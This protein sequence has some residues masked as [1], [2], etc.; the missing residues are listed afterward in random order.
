MAAR[1]GDRLVMQPYDLFSDSRGVD[2]VLWGG[3][4]SLTYSLSKRH[5]LGFNLVYNQNGESET[6]LIEGYALERGDCSRVFRSRVLGYTERNLSSEQVRGTHQPLANYPMRIEWQL[7]FSHVKQEQPDV[8]QIADEYMFWYDDDGHIYDTVYSFGSSFTPPARYWRNINE[9]NR[10]FNLNVMLPVSDNLKAKIGGNYAKKVRDQRQWQFYLQ[11]GGS[12]EYNGN[13]DDYL[14]QTGIKDS[15]L[16][17]PA[18]STYRYNMYSYWSNATYARDQYDAH[19]IVSAGFGQL[20]ARVFG[21]L[22]AVLGLRYEKTDMESRN[23]DT[24]K[25]ANIQSGDWLPAVSLVYHAGKDMNLRFAYGRTLARP[26]LREISTFAQE[27][28]T[29]SRFLHGNP[30]LDYTKIQNYDLRWEWFSRPNEIAAVSLFYKRFENPIEVAMVGSNFDR[31][32]VNVDR[33]T[34]HGAEFELRT[35]MDRAA[36]FLRNF[37]FAAISRWCRQRFK[38]RPMNCRYAAG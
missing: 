21:N 10:E 17:N 7:A 29:G 12:N 5:T 33:A 18:D 3:L 9:K 26:S 2:E 6:R 14:Q 31:M 20:E 19:Q 1:V 4:G 27:E 32:P 34:T 23:Q 11:G 24:S 13:F 8:R 37:S 36:H 38:S 25:P 35:G 28:F 22:D 30:D 16:I 15:T